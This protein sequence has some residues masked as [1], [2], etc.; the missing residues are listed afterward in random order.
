MSVAAIGTALS[1]GS[2][3]VSYGQ[4]LFGSDFDHYRVNSGQVPTD[5]AAFVI[6]RLSFDERAALERQWRANG[7]AGSVP[8]SNPAKLAQMAAGGANG[9]MDSKDRAWAN[10]FIPLVQKYSGAPETAMSNPYAVVSSDRPSAWDQVTGSIGRTIENLGDVFGN[11]AKAGV[12]GALE[13]MEGTSGAAA[14]TSRTIAG[15]SVV[16]LM[17]ILAGV[18]LAWFLS[19]R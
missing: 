14:G 11:T 19:K 12:R 15:L 4:N 10:V 13:G 2:Q 5:V 7:W 8:W 3:L 17:M 16:T 6:S 18:L 1:A 9:E